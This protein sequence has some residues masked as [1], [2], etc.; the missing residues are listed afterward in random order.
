MTSRAL[1]LAVVGSFLAVPRAALVGDETPPPA[2]SSSHDARA[3]AVHVEG[4]DAVTA[5]RAPA[6]LDARPRSGSVPR[7]PALGGTLAAGEPCSAA[8]FEALSGAS[9][10]EAIAGS[11]HNCL[12]ELWSYDA[13]VATVIDGSNIVLVANQM[14][15]DAADVAANASRLTQMAFFYQIAFFHAW[16]QAGTSYDAATVDAAQQA[17]LAIAADP[18]FLAEGAD[19]TRLRSQWATSIDSAEGVRLALDAVLD[20]LQRYNQDPALAGDYYERITVYSL[21]FGLSRQI[22]NNAHLGSGSPWYGIVSSALVEEIAV[23]ALDQDHPPDAEYVVLNALFT[24]GRISALEPATADLAHARVT[25]AYQTFPQYSAPWIEAVGVLD[26]FYGATLHGGAVLDID[27]IRIDVTGAALPNEFVFDNGA[28]VFKT[29]I[30]LPQAEALYDAIQEVESQFFRLCTYLDPVPGDVNST[31]TLVIYASRADYDLYQRFLYNLGTNNGGIFIEAD[32]T[33]FTYDRTPQES[34]YSLED[35]LRHEYVHYLDSRYLV[36]GGFYEAGSLYEG[37]RIVWYTEGLAEYVAG[38]TRVDGIRPR[39]VLVEQ[40][41]GDASRMTIPDVLSATYSGGFTFYRYASM[42][43]AYLHEE[44]PGLLVDLLASVR[45]DDT[46]RVDALFLDLTTDPALQTEY[47][48][49]LDLQVSRVSQGWLFAEDVPTARTPS[50]LP[51]G[52]ASDLLDSIVASGITSAPQ[53]ETVDSRFIYT[54]TLSLIVAGDPASYPALF[55]AALDGQLDD[56]LRNLITEEPNF[57]SATAWFGNLTSSGPTVT[58]DIVIEGPYAPLGFHD[59]LVTPARVKQGHDVTITFTASVPLDGDPAVTVNGQAATIVGQNGNDYTATYTVG[60]NETTGAAT[61][62]VTGTALSGHFGT[63]SDSSLLEVLPRER[64]V[65]ARCA[66]K[67]GRA[68]GQDRIKLSGTLGDLVPY[69]SSIS[70]A[71]AI[72]I[73]ISS[74]SEG[75]TLLSETLPFSA[76]EIDGRDRFKH[77]GTSGGIGSF[78]ID[79]TRGT[80]TLKASALDLTGLR[81]PLR[82]EISCGDYHGEGEA[83]EGVINGPRK[84]SPMV[85]LNGVRDAL[86]VDRLRFRPNGP[87]AGTAGFTAKGGLAVADTSVDLAAQDV[88]VGLGGFVTT[89]P[90]GA[91]ERVGTRNVYRYR[92]TSAGPV[93]TALV[94]LD[95]SRFKIVVRNVDIAAAPTPMRLSVAF[96]GFSQAFDY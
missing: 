25:Q 29:G 88:D 78:M 5:D 43:F 83:G 91:L 53:F 32:G 19:L 23:V 47:D 80:F 10:V 37:D 6:R 36:T 8:E 50:S 77:R 26:D 93:V 74:P 76:S 82:L 44:R 56:R 14:T 27:Q 4:R 38:S 16:Y 72:P 57:R 55:R 20:L 85:L 34:I 84:S 61:I 66:V 79:F 73:V 30:D 12:Y 62:A 89:I 2:N 18:A 31:V 60:E 28:L 59:L 63:A 96:G 48:A 9:L 3:C 40:I 35:L 58:A 70:A 75:V 41:A 81:S 45:A 13:D 90:A 33:L 52:N 24:L 21:L 1:F 65:I 94:D 86:R 67:A 11:S 49:Y 92:G 54:D 42:L 46:A 87:E 71:N 95:R 22:G 69:Y 7:P 15:A 17:L 68:R 51:G 39:R 64:L